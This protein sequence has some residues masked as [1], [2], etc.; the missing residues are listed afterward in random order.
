MSRSRRGTAS[1]LLRLARR[2]RGTSSIHSHER[3][4]LDRVYLPS[5]TVDLAIKCIVSLNSL[6]YDVSTYKSYLKSASP[7]LSYHTEFDCSRS[8]GMS[9]RIDGLIRFFPVRPRR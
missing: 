2:R 5:D 9:T 7:M 6:S 8:D 1:A 4:T 3:S